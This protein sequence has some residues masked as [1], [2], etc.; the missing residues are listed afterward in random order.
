MNP[1]DVL[2]T[3][4]LPLWITSIVALVIGGFIVLQASPRSRKMLAL[5]P[6]ALPLALL[7]IVA[8]LISGIG[9]VLLLVRGAVEG[10]GHYVAEHGQA[11]ISPG[12]GAAIGV[13]LVMALVILIGS[14][15]LASKPEAGTT[16]GQ[17]H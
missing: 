13:A 14:A 16:H 7:G 9:S 3:F 5:L 8:L 6:F 15:I 2:P 17:P 11:G 4:V 10:G 12:A 1:N